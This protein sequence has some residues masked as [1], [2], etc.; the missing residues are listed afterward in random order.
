MTTASVRTTQATPLSWLNKSGLIIAIV[1][2]VADLTSPLQ[3]GPGDQPGPPYP[4]LL[5]DAALGLITIVA[6]VFAWRTA[7]RAAV[8]VTAGSRIVSMITALPA[9]FVDVPAGVKV[10]VG[11]FVLLTVASVVMMLAPRRES[12]RV[13]D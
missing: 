12:A 3:G 7:R 8:R 11:G 5:L 6:A 4:I 9:F 10:L 1:L 2:G 13:P